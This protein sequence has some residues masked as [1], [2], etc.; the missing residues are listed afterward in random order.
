M[1]AQDKSRL[2]TAKGAT[3]RILHVYKDFDPIGGGGGVARHIHG[4]AQGLAGDGYRVRVVAPS[5]RDA[6]ASYEVQAAS[7]AGL[8]RQVQW[9]NVVH[10]H[11]SRV[12]YSAWAGVLGFALGRRVVYT[13]HC[14]Y[15]H[16]RP[17]A[18]VAWDKLIERPLL[19]KCHAVFVLS[20]YWR[21]YL[22][23]RGL[24]TRHIHTV[25][26][27]VTSKDVLALRCDRAVTRL[28]GS[29]AILS[30]GRLDPVKR[31][32][33]AIAALSEPGLARAMLHIVGKGPDEQRLRADA[34]RLGVSRQ[35]QFYGYASDKQVAAMAAGADVF[36]MPS[37]AEGLPTVII[38]MLILGVPVVAS[39]I[40]G[41]L[42]VMKVAGLDTTY[43]TGDVGA[44]AEAI[45]AAAGSKVPEPVKASITK[46]FSW[47]STAQ[48]IAAVYAG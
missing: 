36:V 1:A 4:L 46:A 7:F 19:S 12:P 23:D 38:E 33:D 3:V 18:K 2:L 6:H 9:A 34:K 13:P 37:E 31:I 20:E 28:A 16:D 29:P 32:H 25:P 15:D 11:G 27:C 10:I 5:P 41:N 39:H 42:A 22:R 8:V 47:E 43:P 26:N 14:Y 17:W 48:R 35:T 24:A 45:K 44:L 40:P 30:V 21:G